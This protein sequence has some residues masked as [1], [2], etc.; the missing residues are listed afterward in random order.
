MKDDVNFS[1]L[2][3]FYCV[4]HIKDMLFHRFDARTHNYNNV[5]TT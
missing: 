1:L 4:N 5:N 2:I 3:K